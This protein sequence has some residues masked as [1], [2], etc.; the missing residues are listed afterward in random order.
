MA[1]STDIDV[2]L[3]WVREERIGHAG[4]KWTP[5]LEDAISAHPW[6]DG[7]DGWRFWLLQYLDRS[8][9]LGLENPRGLQALGKF[10]TTAVD[11]LSS[12]ER[13]YG[14]LPAPGLPSGEIATWEHDQ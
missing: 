3:A 2:A 14:P 11:M 7:P 13:V 4:D 1:E 6:A 10:V 8:R 5:E 12:I 9:L